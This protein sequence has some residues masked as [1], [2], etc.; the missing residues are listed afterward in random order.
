[1][2]GLIP[3]PRP[4]C[5]ASRESPQAVAADSKHTFKDKFS[6]KFSKEAEDFA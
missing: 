3:Q 6:R 2:F 4:R 5:E 1:M